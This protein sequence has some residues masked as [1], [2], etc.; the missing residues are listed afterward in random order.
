MPTGTTH[1]IYLQQDK[2]AT[3][4]TLDDRYLQVRLHTAQ[5]Y[6]EAPWL[7]QVAYMVCST[8]VTS[9]FLTDHVSRSIHRVATVQK[10]TPCPLGLQVNLTDWLPAVRQQ[11]ISLELKLT[12]VRDKPF[13][14]L[15]ERLG[16]MGLDTKLSLV[17]AELGIGARVAEVAGHILSAL[18]EEGKAHTVLALRADLN[19]NDLQAGYYA[20]LAPYR[21]DDIP[22]A[23]R[24]R[25][26]GQL[27]DPRAPFSEKNTYAVLEIGVFERRGEEA[28]RAEP[29]WHTLQDAYHEA[30]H[31][32][33]HSDRD[34][35]KAQA[36]WL[37]ALGQAQRM[38]YNDRSFLL[39]EIK[40]I[41]QR[42]TLE[43]Q[44]ALRPATVLEAKSADLLPEEW[45][46]VLGVASET[47][48][49]Q[50]VAAYQAALARSGVS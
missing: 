26:N 2:P 47:E 12:A 6:V 11:S 35:R 25:D 46:Q 9:S 15:S 43:V 18:L 42:Y 16:Q 7:T 31:T 37:A 49:V 33:I 38:A 14:I 22:L 5:A 20:M 21:A 27:D 41:F 19:V 8:E 1:L 45:Q 34:Y 4:L 10:N 13:G 29:W 23:L 28:A 44:Q 40:Q 39:P 48:L 3:A 36:T 30:I 24:L 50:S 32:P 17:R